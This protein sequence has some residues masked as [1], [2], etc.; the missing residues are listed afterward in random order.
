MTHEPKGMALM[1]RLV[2]SL[3]IAVAALLAFLSTACGVLLICGFILLEWLVGAVPWA[4]KDY[5]VISAVVWLVSHVALCAVLFLGWFTV[6]RCASALL[7]RRRWDGPTA[8]SALAIGIVVVTY[9]VS[10]CGILLC[11]FLAYA[12][13]VTDLVVRT[14][15]R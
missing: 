3:G 2:A 9:M 11:L 6:W 10:L 8:T 14:M 7:G 4:L 13:Y 15:G 5:Y 1:L 12:P